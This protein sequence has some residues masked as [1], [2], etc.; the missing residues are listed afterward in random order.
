MKIFNEALSNEQL[1]K[2]APSL[3][4]DEPYFEASEKYHFISTID[5]IEA[6]REHSW[7]PVGVSEA[8]VRDEKKDGFQKHCVRFRHLDDLLK[9]GENSVELLL[10]N[11]HDRSKSFSISLGV[12]RFVCANGL[13]VAD[14]IFGS[15]QIRHLGERDND[16]SFAIEHIAQAKHQILDK[17]DL[18]SKIELSKDDKA[19]FAKAVI[20]LRFESHLQVDFNDLL[21]PHRVEDEKDDLYT[22]FNTIQEHLIRGNLSG[23]NTQTNRRFTS[24][25]IKSISTDTQINQRLWS[26]AENIA[27]IKS[28]ANRQ[29][30]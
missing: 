7:Y 19:S 24:K 16:V 26:L 9:P 13:V 30:A 22:T 25:E 4:A 15:Y 2:L 5:V 8:S 12:F 3:F 11:S 1:E 27:K 29:V 21:V 6:I 28:T 17:I 18:F 10:F 20:P 14:E 23:T